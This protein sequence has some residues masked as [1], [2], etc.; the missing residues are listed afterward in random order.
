MYKY[1]KLCILN[2]I[3]LLQKLKL[4]KDFAFRAFYCK[5]TASSLKIPPTFGLRLANW[6]NKVDQNFKA[7]Y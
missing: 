7:I 4:S 2:C 3:C 1:L 6:L 5:T